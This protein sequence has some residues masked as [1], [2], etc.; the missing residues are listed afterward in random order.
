MPVESAA[1]SNPKM[2]TY[3]P[4]SSKKEDR[5]DV[6]VII[7]TFNSED[8]IEECLNSVYQNEGS[9]RQE[10]I[11]VDNDS[12]DK[13]VEIVRTQ[14]PIVRLLTPRENLGFA[15]A[16]N[17]AAQQS[18]AAYILL[19]NPDTV[20][21]DKAVERAYNFARK[22][23]E[24][25]YYGGRTLKVDRSL[26][27]SSCWGQPT[28]W[29]LFTF[30]TGLS[31]IFKH[32]GL[33]DPESLG[34]WK[35]NTVREVGV[36]TGC[37]LLVEQT[38]WKAINGFDEHFWLYGEDVDLAIRARKAG[39][40]PVIYPDA[41]VV[42]EV[43]QSSTSAQKSIWLHRGKV[44]C[45]KRNWNG[46]SRTIAIMLLKTGILLRSAAYRILG[47]PENHWVACW[48]RRAEWERGHPTTP[49]T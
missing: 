14:F 48:S 39:Y 45:I 11:V 26:E 30:A 1:N 15:K 23:P 17:Y 38:A 9:I 47:S 32:N 6:S 40:R 43:G 28:L 7:V 35:R 4:L 3:H 44:S 46:F 36:I 41:V 2:N 49:K 25:G 34:S 8:Q 29:S 31:T 42:H 37:F 5:P 10:V 21:L 16:C 18:E 19:L 13:T 22:N 27:R 33:F 24:Y 12:K 20:V